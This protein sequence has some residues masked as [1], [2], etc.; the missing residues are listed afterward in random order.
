MRVSSCDTEGGARADNESAEPKATLQAFLNLRALR[1]LTLGL[2]VG[3]GPS[4]SW[5]LC[6]TSGRPMI[7]AMSN[8]LNR[9]LQKR[10]SGR[11]CTDSRASKPRAVATPS[12][13][14]AACGISPASRKEDRLSGSSSLISAA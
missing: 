9:N 7:R 4:S 14:T 13:A 6:N 11:A 3:A 1:M 2:S 10:V 5:L 12:S 8:G